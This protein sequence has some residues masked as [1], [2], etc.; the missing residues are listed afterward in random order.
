MAPYRFVPYGKTLM[1]CDSEKLGDGCYLSQDYFNSYSAVYYPGIHFILIY[2]IF[3][4]DILFEEQKINQFQ[5][6]SLE[7]V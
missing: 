3:N 6:I 5:T 2:I 1:W 7:S 4:H